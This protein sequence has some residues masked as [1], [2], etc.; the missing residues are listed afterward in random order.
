MKSTFFLLFTSL[1]TLVALSVCSQ[2]N[3]RHH[4]SR[5]GAQLRKR[6]DGNYDDGDYEDDGPDDSNSVTLRLNGEEELTFTTIGLLA[7]NEWFEPPPKFIREAEIVSGPPGIHIVFIAPSPSAGVDV[8]AD[9][10]RE[11][12]EM[13]FISPVIRLPRTPEEGALAERAGLTPHRFRLHPEVPA[14]PADVASSFLVRYPERRVLVALEMIHDGPGEDDFT[15]VLHVDFDQLTPK[16]E[17]FGSI[18][19]DGHQGQNDIFGYGAN[20]NVR[21]ARVLAEPIEQRTICTLG[22]WENLAATL[23]TSA[24]QKPDGP[25][26][27]AEML[28]CKET[29]EDEEE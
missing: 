20:P 4:D 15:N 19:L 14:F 7:T 6:D 16:G 27:G 23:F 3:A 17:R 5:A 8:G 24:G 22:K 25:I 26:Y 21:R 29:L 11:G 10:A 2:I 18:E 13:P 12:S 1:C 9:A 28:L